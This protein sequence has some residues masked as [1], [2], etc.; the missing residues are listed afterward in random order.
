MFEARLDLTLFLTEPTGRTLRLL[1]CPRRLA[2]PSSLLATLELTKISDSMRR[3]A[4]AVVS[5]ARGLNNAHARPLREE[6]LQRLSHW[7]WEETGRMVAVGLLVT[8][9]IILPQ[10]T[11]GSLRR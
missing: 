7:R 2:R 10:S 9:M 5:I 3:S 4:I 6:S 8:S 11:L 1:S